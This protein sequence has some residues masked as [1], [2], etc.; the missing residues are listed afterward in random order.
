MTQ[1]SLPYEKRSMHAAMGVNLFMAAAGV[2]AGTL[3]HSAALM[4]DGL[5]SLIGFLSAVFGLLVAKLLTRSAD[6]RRPFGCATEEV[7][8]ASF[9]ALMIAGLVLAAG[10]GAVEKIYAYVSTGQYTPLDYNI[11]LVYSLIVLTACL[12]L[13]L[14]HRHNW[15]K[16]GKRSEILRME[17]QATTIDSA[18]TAA[19]G[20]GFGLIYLFGH[21][22]LA[23]VAPVGDAV[24]VMLMCLF[25]SKGV[26]QTVRMSFAELLNAS[27]PAD[28]VLAAKRIV[29]DTAKMHG[30][31]AWEVSVVKHGRVH[32]VQFR[33]DPKA[34]I[35]AAEFDRLQQQFTQALNKK[36]PGTEVGFA[37]APQLEEEKP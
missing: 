7:V 30:M 34:A 8:F 6:R 19:A 2:V 37:L 16:T 11:I 5:F 3:A 35:T 24:I 17:A 29:R 15:K 13:W 4:M 1:D 10:L 32:I 23:P 33:L 21:S 28:A 25:F 9:R 22:W 27:A 20:I 12:A 14:Y 31:E 36:L 18:I 26:V